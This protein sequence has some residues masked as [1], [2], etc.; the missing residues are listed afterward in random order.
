LLR[1]KPTAIHQTAG[2]ASAAL[3]AGCLLNT[4]LGVL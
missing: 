1:K 4:S 2:T 3:D